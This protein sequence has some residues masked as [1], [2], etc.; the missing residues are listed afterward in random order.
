[1]PWQEWEHGGRRALEPK[2]KGRKKEQKIVISITM[3]MYF[4]RKCGF[5]FDT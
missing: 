1:M 4:I 2:R 5:I 3:K